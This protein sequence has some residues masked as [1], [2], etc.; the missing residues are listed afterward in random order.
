MKELVK[1]ATERNVIFRSIKIAAIVGTVLMIINH[2]DAILAGEI[3]G[4]RI[5][6]IC[7]TYL[8]PFSVSTISSTLQ[9]LD[10]MNSIKN[11]QEKL[12][13]VN[14]MVKAILELESWFIAGASL[15]A[16]IYLK[17][18]L[19]LLI[20]FFMLPDISMVGY[21]KNKTMGSIVYNA[22]HNYALVLA[23]II[24]GFILNIKPLIFAGLIL[25]LHICVDR[26]FG[27]GLKYRTGFEDTHMQKI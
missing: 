3:S 6:Q 10:S 20:V 16:Y 24:A 7:L 5:F 14:N 25:S 8:V 18:N 1:I 12:I 27:F 4:R 9:K 23:L 11:K 21:L 22:V 26:F 19:G 2:Y 15:L 17:G 13:L